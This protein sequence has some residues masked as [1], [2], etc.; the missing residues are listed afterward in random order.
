[1]EQLAFVLVSSS[2]S[3]SV[4]VIFT[5]CIL[6]IFFGSALDATRLHAEVAQEANEGDRSRNLPRAGDTNLPLMIN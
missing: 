5:F 6:A 1:M 3:S 4:R 2:P